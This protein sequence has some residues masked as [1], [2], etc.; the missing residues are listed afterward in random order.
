MVALMRLPE[1]L[2]CFDTHTISC[3]FSR[4]ETPPLVVNPN[5]DVARISMYANKVEQFKDLDVKL[6]G[7]LKVA[8]FW[9]T[10]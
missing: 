2:H 10:T 6:V 4:L 9:H 3:I 8:Q 5:F 1:N 7:A